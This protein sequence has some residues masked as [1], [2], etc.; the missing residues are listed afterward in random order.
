MT[1]IQCLKTVN[2]VQEKRTSSRHWLKMAQSMWTLPMIKEELVSITIC[3]NALA[4]FRIVPSLIIT[5]FFQLY[6]WL[7]KTVNNWVDSI[8]LKLFIG[9]LTWRRDIFCL[10]IVLNGVHPRQMNTL[11]LHYK[12]Q[13]HS[14]MC[15]LS[16][17]SNRIKL[18]HLHKITQAEAM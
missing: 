2:F 1:L 11:S 10:V 17:F 16:S 14:S 7:R 15:H 8:W 6:I 4:N 18:Y 9:V 13:C 3:A 12:W 5:I